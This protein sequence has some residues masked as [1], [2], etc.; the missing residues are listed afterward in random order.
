MSEEQQ[1]FAIV[2]LVFS[3]AVTVLCGAVGLGWQGDELLTALGIYPAGLGFVFWPALGYSLAGAKS[4]FGRGL[5]LG[6]VTGYDY[7]V[8]ER[9]T[10][11]GAGDPSLIERLWGGNK[12][13]LTALAVLYVGGQL[14]VVLPKAWGRRRGTGPDNNGPDPP[15]TFTARRPPT[16]R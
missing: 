13:G 6:A 4:D 10:A 11:P 1:E 5:C 8:V 7:W 12:L 16:G 2:G 9:L 14:A 3:A 15:P